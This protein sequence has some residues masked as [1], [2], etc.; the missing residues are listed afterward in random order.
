MNNPIIH[1]ELVGMLRTGKA[2]ALQVGLVL[3]LA[4]L[5]VLRWP[6]EARVDMSYDQS[7]QVLSIFAYGLMVGVILLAPVFPATSIVRERQQGTLW[8]LLNSPMSS[9]TIL[10]GKLIGTLGFVL[11]LL[12]LSLPAAAACYTMGGV[13]LVGQLMHVYMILFLAAM[14]YATLGIL[15]STYSS[16]TDSALR[17]TYGLILAMALLPLGPHQLEQSLLAGWLA[18]AVDWFRCVSPIPAMLEAM[19]HSAIEMRGTTGLGNVAFRYAILALGF[20]A[21][22]LVWTTARLNFRL[23]D[24]ARK[25]GKIT[26]ERA[27]AVRAYRR[28]MFL[29]F[30]D[31]NRRSE[32]IGRWANPVRVKEFR[33]RRFGRSHW[34]MRL[35]GFCMIVSLALMLAV[36][37]ATVNWGAE[38]L[39]TILVLLSI[40][41]VIL[42]TPSLASGL[43]SGERESG[44]W[45][46]LMMTPLRASHIISGKLTSVLWTL[47]L[48][49][50]STLPAYALL[51]LIDVA[52]KLA[53]AETM[54]T[55][56]L[57]ACFSLLLSAAM[58]SLFQRTATATA[59][60]YA[61]LVGLCAGTLLFWLGRGAPFTHGTVQAVL[62]I[63]PLAA[64]LALIEAPGFAD[65]DLTPANWWFMGGGCVLCVLVLFARTLRLT[66]PT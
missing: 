52:N 49:L 28:I 41:L 48:V 60:S 11:L 10:F 31:P 29:W 62:R 21:L 14:Q 58:S 3:V 46:L 39:G 23:F 20:I 33:S 35:V 1:R 26:D 9:V 50:V 55:L 2:L 6:S 51:D 61:L 37:S 59:V 65:L 18:D 7:Q 30:F 56:V 8:L 5:V 19:R 54:I 12:V 66:Q 57:T 64:A 15:I 16:S 13:D 45:R 63:N 4:A 36:V 24:R 44:G 34:L 17:V 47:A 27:T 38:I 40:G 42:L 25:V 22:F 43:I 53:I 32:L